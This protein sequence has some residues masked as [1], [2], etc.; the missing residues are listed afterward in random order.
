M[1]VR[2]SQNNKAQPAALR[3]APALEA[4]I[5]LCPKPRLPLWPGMLQPASWAM[6]ELPP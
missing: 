4:S 2:S 3:R 6:N 5:K 1:G